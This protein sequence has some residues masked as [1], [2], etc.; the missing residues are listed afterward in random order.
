MLSIKILASLLILTTTVA[1]SVHQAGNVT[2]IPGARKPLN[3]LECDR[4]INSTIHD[5]FGVNKSIEV[6]NGNCNV[7]LQAES[8]TKLEVSLLQFNQ[9]KLRILNSCRNYPGMVYLTS[10]V[11]MTITYNE[12]G[13]FPTIQIKDKTENE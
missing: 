2:C 7:R 12:L 4:A 13:I 8:G 3:E 11:S 9:G 5:M 6:L 10:N 1:Q